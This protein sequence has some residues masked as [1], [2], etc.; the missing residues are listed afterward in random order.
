[1]LGMSGTVRSDSHMICDMLQTDYM[2]EVVADWFEILL[3][4]VVGFDVL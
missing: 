4:V 2:W 1:M 3:C